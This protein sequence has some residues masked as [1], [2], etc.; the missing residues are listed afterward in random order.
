MNHIL[1]AEYTET[2]AVLQDQAFGRALSDVNQI[3][4]EDFGKG[5]DQLFESFEPVPRAAA[6]LAQV[7]PAV[8]KE[9]V[10]VAVKVQY[11]DMRVGAGCSVRCMHNQA[12]ATN[13]SIAGPLQW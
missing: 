7:H 12:V 1:P 13:T 3:F 5:I 4:I 9:G 2:L 6:S 11:I 8:T 10:R